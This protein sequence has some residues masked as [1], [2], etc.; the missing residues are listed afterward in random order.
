MLL[1]HLGEGSGVELVSV[2]TTTSL[3]GMNARR[4]FG[5]TAV[6]TDVDEVLDDEGL[7]AVVV[8]TRHH[9]HA[10]FV[11]QALQRG[12]GRR[13]VFVEKPLA[14]TGEQLDDVLDAVRTS[15][16]DRLMVGFNRRFAPLLTELQ[17]R[18]GVGPGDGSGSGSGPLAARYLVNAGRLDATSWYLD[19]DREGS[20][21]AGE[22]GHFIDTVSALLGQDPV[23]VYAVGTGQDV[24]AVLTYPD[25]ST[26]TIA[27]LAGGSSKFPKESI[28]LTGGARSARLDNFQRVSV[29]TP[30]G[31]R[32]KRSMTIDKGQRGQLAAFVDAV[33]DGA[34]MP[35]GLDS[36]V[37]TT[38]ATL[39]VGLSAA[40]RRAVSW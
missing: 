34:P 39:A 27:Y 6:T 28:D 8:V 7:D 10:A 31:K 35:I 40:E 25:S 13:A 16:N 36:L 4:K 23:E 24:Q 18:F 9:S 20:R 3:S 21:F 1:P 38:R 30:N 5:F 12:G 17:A 29:W 11:R 2:A 19:A 22:G 15:G 32:T 33:R 37:A 26:A 14:L